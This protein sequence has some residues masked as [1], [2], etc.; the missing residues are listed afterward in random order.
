[1]TNTTSDRAAMSQTPDLGP[2]TLTQ[3]RDRWRFTLT[4]PG[5]I[6]LELPSDYERFLTERLR[7]LLGPAAPPAIEMD[8]QGLPGISSRQLGLM[9]ALQKSLAD[10]C[11]KLCVT[12]LS[13]GVRRL[14]NLTRTEQF[15]EIG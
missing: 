2:L 12:G 7:P 6:M 8:L 14:L 5:E 1:M 11:E 15:F 9:L 10:R 13:E 4:T 3:E